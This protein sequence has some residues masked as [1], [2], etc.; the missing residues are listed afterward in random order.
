MSS[1]LETL[2][3]YLPEPLKTLAINSF[4]ILWKRKRFGPVFHKAWPEFVERE[5]YTAEEWRNYQ[6]EK[7]RQ[8]LVHAF[9]TVP[10]YHA[11]FRKK[12]FDKEYLKKFKLE[13]LPLLPLVEKDTLRAYPESFL[14]SVAPRKKLYSL[15]TA[16]STGTPLKIWYTPEIHALNNAVREA[17]SRRW[18][19]VIPPNQTKPPFWVYNYFERQLYLSAF[20]ISPANIP[21]YVKALNK[22]KPDYLEGYAF[23]HFF[24]ARMIGELGLDVHKPRCVI[25]SSEKLTNEMKKTIE[26]VYRTKVFDEYGNVEG[27]CFASECASG[28]LHISPDVGI[29]ELIKENGEYAADGEIGEIVATGLLNFHQPL[30]RYRIG[31]LAIPVSKS[32]QCGRQMP[33]L[34]EIVG[35]LQDVVISVDGREIVGLYRLFYDIASIRE[36]QV[37]QED[38]DHIRILLVLAKSLT[39]EEEKIIK[40]RVKERIG[41]DVRVDLEI[42]DH[43]HRTERGKFRLVISKVSR[44]LKNK[45]E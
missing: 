6:E 11:S 15:S 9:E 3:P 35:R 14:S 45:Y 5:K 25:T 4:A 44:R 40:N 23:S 34:K 27:C 20:H 16:G 2:V 41:N 13:E 39:S 1:K 29:V 28:S 43:I 12:G 38:Y 26:D 42:V 32:C 33:V 18:A 31:D 24:L 36:G 7:L 10:Y 8:L 19:G 37:I 30:I 21:Y 22:Y 17:R